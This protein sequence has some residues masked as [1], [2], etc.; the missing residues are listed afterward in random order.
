MTEKEA[1]SQTKIWGLANISRQ[2]SQLAFITVPPSSDQIKILFPKGF[3]LIVIATVWTI[4][5]DVRGGPPHLTI[6]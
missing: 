1:L 3:Q 4:E 6:E 5:I 2:H